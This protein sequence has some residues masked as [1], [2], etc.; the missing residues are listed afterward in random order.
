M[1]L[2]KPQSQSNPLE[3]PV[4]SSKKNTSPNQQQVDEANAHGTYGGFAKL[5]PLS[6]TAPKA[7]TEV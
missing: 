2:K 5:E 1:K 4:R 7:N 6:N 3:K